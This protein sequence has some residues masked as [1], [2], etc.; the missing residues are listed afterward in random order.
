VKRPLTN[1]QLL[2]A[3]RRIHQ[4]VRESVIAA[5][6]SQ[7]YEELCGE[8]TAAAGDTI[9]AI[10]RIA[11][12]TL[13]AGINEV[14]A[15]HGPI[16][17]IGEGVPDG[18]IVLP[19]GAEATDAAWRLIVDPIDGTRGLMFQKRPAW[20]LTAAAPNRGEATS[21]ADIQVAVQTEL[22]LVKQHLCDSFWAIQ[23][24]GAH[25]ERTNR[26]TAASEPLELQP[27]SAESLAHG[28]ATVCS[29]F[30]GGRDLIGIIADELSHRLLAGNQPAEARIFED[31]YASTA[32]QLAGLMMGQ[33]RFVADLRPLL[34]DAVHQ[35]GGT[36]GHCCHPYDLC[37]KLIAEETGVTICLPNGA[38]ISVPLDTES[39]VTWVGYA[40][41]KL[42]EKIEPVLRQILN[43]RGILSQT[44]S[45]RE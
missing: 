43:E 28:Y 44:E 13:L 15:P 5:C 25:A 24:L 29:F 20:I 14:I 27:S 42:L 18:E 2:A 3:I 36:L 37:T 19:A 31:Q 10:D 1:D 12:K 38:P 22:P 40:N 39:D 41:G 33:D 9:Y 21:L 4:G 16:V 11:E 17:V 30:A 26:L 32:G 6:E 45:R 7:A 35:R 34:A 8:A 23:G